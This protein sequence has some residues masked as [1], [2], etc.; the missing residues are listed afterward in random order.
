MRFVRTALLAGTMVGLVT[1]SSMIAEA[2]PSAS[3][4]GSAGASTGASGAVDAEAVL[5]KARRALD[6]GKAAAAQQLAD[7]VLTSAKKDA[8]STARALAMRGEAYLALGRPVEAIADLDSALWVKGGL[9]G[10]DRERA[11]A[12]RSKAMASSGVSGGGGGPVAAS[13]PSTASGGAAGAGWSSTVRAAPDQPSRAMS[14]TAPATKASQSGSGSGIGGFFSKIFGGGK[15]SGG[16]P[17][18][19]GTVLPPAS[20]LRGP[21]VSSYAPQRL[22]TERAETPARVVKPARAP[23]AARGHAPRQAA[24]AKG[25][26]TLQLA[27]VRTKAEAEDMARKAKAGDRSLGSHAFEIVESVYGNMGRFYRVRI[28][29]FANETKAASTCAALRARNVD[30]MVLDAASSNG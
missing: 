26:F 28:G 24:P 15:S 3:K 20:P 8:R 22:E 21:E 29:S 1:L 5:D 14:T 27:A 25:G 23:P 18:T 13:A 30:C 11:S 7:S 19:T 9:A 4:E 16:S 17:S 6:A 2:R 10:Q 12:A